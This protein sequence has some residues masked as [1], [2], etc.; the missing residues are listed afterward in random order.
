[1]SAFTEVTAQP[2]KDPRGDLLL[3]IR[4]KRAKV[5]IYLAGAAARRRRL[6]NLT[7]IAGT[8]AAALTAAPAFG[9]KP[10]A[11]WLTTTLGLSSPSW[12]LLC[13]LAAVCSIAATIATQLL[14]SHNVEE[15]LARAQDLQARLEVVDV[16]VMSGK[17]DYSRAA[18]EY[19]ACIKAASFIQER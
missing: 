11:D 18:D 14:K 15:H 4:A 9:G 8:F 1:M 10:L 6:L 16:G 19:E 3:W 17:L 12:R 5:E 2:G 7:I 13:A